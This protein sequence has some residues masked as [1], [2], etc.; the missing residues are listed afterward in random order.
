MADTE[1]RQCWH[2]LRSVV[3]Q[4]YAETK[5]TKEREEEFSISF[6]RTYNMVYRLCKHNPEW[7][8]RKLEEEA[9]NWL[10][11]LR[12]RLVAQLSATS[13]M[14]RH[15]RCLSLG[16]THLL[17]CSMGVVA[18]VDRAHKFLIAV[19]KKY[20]D[21]CAASEVL[22]GVLIYLHNCFLKQFEITF[23]DVN[24]VRMVY[25]PFVGCEFIALFGFSCQ[26]LFW[27]TVYL[28][29]IL[30]I[31]L[32]RLKSQLKRSDPVLQQYLSFEKKLKD[33]RSRWRQLK[34]KVDQY[35]LEKVCYCS[36]R[37]FKYSMLAFDPHSCSNVK[38]GCEPNASFCSN[39]GKSWRSNTAQGRRSTLTPKQ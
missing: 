1:R 19:Q 29:P 37:P 34:K 14:C 10:E 30:Q 17:R 31:S 26:G 38:Q 39:G 12:E 28:D 20:D 21:L 4:I 16:D 35:S 11:V 6:E 13:G 3:R 25:R 15:T 22:N 7:L 33:T 8:Y 5:A 9:Q 27:E 32:P 23:T 24:R 18:S 36:P 2:E